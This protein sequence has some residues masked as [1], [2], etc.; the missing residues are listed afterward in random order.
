MPL[1]ARRMEVISQCPQNIQI[2]VGLNSSTQKTLKQKTETLQTHLCITHFCECAHS[3]SQ[4]IR[5]WPVLKGRW[6]FLGLWSF[7]VFSENISLSMTSLVHY[8]RE[9]FTHKIICSL[10]KWEQIRENLNASKG[11]KWKRL[12]ITRTKNRYITPQKHTYK[13]L[14]LIN[15]DSV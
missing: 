9:D 10:C 15:I 2:R 13:F 8:H 12:T 4:G 7:L 14:S 1:F 5:I 3:R 6:R 11:Y